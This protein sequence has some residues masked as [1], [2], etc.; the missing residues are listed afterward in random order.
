MS[1]ALQASENVE[2]TNS[3]FYYQGR[4]SGA[5]QYGADLS[6]VWTRFKSAASWS[7]RPF[8]SA[9]CAARK[10]VSASGL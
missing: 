3:F 6:C 1:P 8:C 7:Y 2:A 9:I 5:S 4:R 10:F